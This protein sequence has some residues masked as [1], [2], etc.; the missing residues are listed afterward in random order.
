[1]ALGFLLGWTSFTFSLA[2]SEFRV[3]MLCIIKHLEIQFFFYY[4]PISQPINLSNS[5][6]RGSSWKA[7]ARN[8]Q[9]AKDL[10]QGLMGNISSSHDFL[11]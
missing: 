11:C 1:M 7:N 4:H 5:H 2:W 8:L 10:Y 9:D 3:L 6:P